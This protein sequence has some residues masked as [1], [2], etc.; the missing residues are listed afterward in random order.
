M[1]VFVDLES[2]SEEQQP[3]NSPKR[4]RRP[5]NPHVLF[6]GIPEDLKSQITETNI[7]LHRGKAVDQLLVGAHP[8]NVLAA[9]L[10]CYP[11]ALAMVLWPISATD[12]SP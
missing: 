11:Y 1:A 4:D 8:T 10:T 7:I 2:D 9:V 6:S 5:H 12:L 3:Q